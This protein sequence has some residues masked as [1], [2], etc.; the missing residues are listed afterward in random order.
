M[1]DIWGQNRTLFNSKRDGLVPASLKT[2]VMREAA[3]LRQGNSLVELF[4][5]SAGFV[6][7]RAESQ[8]HSDPARYLQ[9]FRGWEHLATRLVQAVCV[10]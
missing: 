2:S 10:Q 5:D 3:V 7:V 1:A 8:P 9:K 4:P 6:S